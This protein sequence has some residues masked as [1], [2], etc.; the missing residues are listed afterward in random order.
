M[1]RQLLVLRHAKSAWDTDARTDFERPLAKRGRKDAKRMGCWMG[2]QG[3]K[4]DYVLSSPA[5]RAKET[6]LA[7]CAELGLDTETIHWQ[8]RIYLADLDTLLEVLG[9]CPRKARKVL[10]VGHNPGVE[11]LVAYLGGEGV[12]TPPDG[13]LMPTAALARLDMPKDWSR[14]GPGVARLLELTRPKEI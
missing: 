4:P 6:V 14:P 13:K 10:L 8:P 11:E 2:G 7:V 1:S 12:V 5:Q 9:E 3:L